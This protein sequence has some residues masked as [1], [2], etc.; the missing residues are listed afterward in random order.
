MSE[1]HA[2]QG[3]RKLKDALVGMTW[4]QKWEHF[5]T[6]YKEVTIAVVIGAI[7][8]VCCV[9]EFVKPKTQIIMSGTAVNMLI[10]ENAYL[11]LTEDV[12]APLGATEEQSASLFYARID[13]MAGDHNA[14]SNYEQIT[15]LM[16][17]ISTG[18][19]DYLLLDEV[20][21]DYFLQQ[22]HFMDLNQ[23]LTPA[24][25]ETLSDMLVWQELEDGQT[26]PVAVDLAGTGFAANCVTE[27]G[28]LYIAFPGNTGR[29]SSIP[30]LIDHL[31]SWE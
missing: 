29:N 19:L 1:E 3:Y 24:Q 17:M 15:K 23:L 22:D 25:L 28:N 10:T 7:L 8:I 13:D 5:W 6:Y 31:L 18:D 30:L 9:Y 12:L 11:Y 27:S 14:V 2:D 16:A 4:K 20:A 26:A 21:K